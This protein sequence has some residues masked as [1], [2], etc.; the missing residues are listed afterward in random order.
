M[1]QEFSGLQSAQTFERGAYLAP[2]LYHVEV[3][4]CLTKETEKSGKAF[5]VELRILESSNPTH[6]VGTLATYFQKMADRKIAFPA[7]KEFIAGALSYD[8]KQPEAKDLFEKHINPYIE[9]YALAATDGR[10]VFKGRKV[11][12]QVDLKKTKRG[13]D[14]S[15]HTWIVD[16]NQP[17]WTMPA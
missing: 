11:F 9:Q 8:M 6:A 7:I 12:V 17:A 4:R 1:S 13:F 5:I 16:P 2:G 3:V 15:Q 14:F 10:N